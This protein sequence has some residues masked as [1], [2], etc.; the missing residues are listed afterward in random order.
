MQQ[1]E[2]QAG[3]L[4]SSHVE[5]AGGHGG[6][7]VEL[8]SRQCALTMKRANSMWGCTSRSVMSRGC[9]CFLLFSASEAD[10]EYYV[11]FWL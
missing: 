2:L 7:Q 10:Q 11:P 3:W 5:K 9:Y 1:E 6:Q 4:E 8:I